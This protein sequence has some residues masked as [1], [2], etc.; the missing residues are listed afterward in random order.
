[1]PPRHQLRNAKLRATMDKVPLNYYD[2]ETGV[3]FA[4]FTSGFISLSEI[5]YAQKRA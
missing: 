1:V 2:I 5:F 3:S 4:G